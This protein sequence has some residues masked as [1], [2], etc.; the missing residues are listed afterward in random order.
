MERTIH[1]DSRAVAGAS[2]MHC[3]QAIFLTPLSNLTS[4]SFAFT[5]WV[6]YSLISVFADRLKLCC[7]E[8][9]L[10]FCYIVD[11]TSVAGA[12]NQSPVL[13]FTL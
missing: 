12:C 9:C 4:E 13:A 1:S 6:S 11:S 10:G 3:T 7:N 5:F 2:A 8:K